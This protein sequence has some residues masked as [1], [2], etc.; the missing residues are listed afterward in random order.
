MIE[1]II[2][3]ILIG[4]VLGYMIV[5]FINWLVVDT[6][7]EYMRKRMKEINERLDKKSVEWEREEREWRSNFLSED[8]IKWI[9]GCVREDISNSSLLNDDELL[10]CIKSVFNYD[11]GHLERDDVEQ[12]INEK[13]TERR[14]QILN[15]ILN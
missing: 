9:L 8:N 11:I 10:E 13:I 5:F 4:V 7:D 2:K 1:S 12:K 6:S 14:E 3:D 15:D